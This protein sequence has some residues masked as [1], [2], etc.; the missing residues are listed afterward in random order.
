MKD[1]KGPER[2][3]QSRLLIG[4][5]HFSHLCAKSNERW[6]RAVICQRVH[7]NG[8]WS[9]HC[10]PSC[11][12][13]LHTPPCRDVKTFLSAGVMNKEGK[14]VWPFSHSAEDCCNGAPPR[15]GSYRAFLLNHLPARLTPSHNKDW[16]K[17]Q[18]HKPVEEI[19]AINS[20]STTHD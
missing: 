5:E 14:K 6:E 7:L 10:V 18:G 1:W 9:C 2:K 4:L 20:F 15:P 17:T 19:I 3:K 13:Y 11:H 12:A 16:H 8:G